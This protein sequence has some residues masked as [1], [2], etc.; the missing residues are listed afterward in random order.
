[1]VSG[2]DRP[3]PDAHPT[4]TP[5]QKVAINPIPIANDV[6]RCLCPGICLGELTGDP[7]GTRMRGHTYPK[8]HAATMLENQKSI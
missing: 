1:M 5:D 8:D 3:I 7:F 6:L 4:Q 2:C